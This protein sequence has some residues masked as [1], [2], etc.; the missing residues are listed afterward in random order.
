MPIT[1]SSRRIPIPYAAAR[2]G[3]STSVL[4]EAV[5]QGELEYCRLGPRRI[6][7]TTPVWIGEWASRRLL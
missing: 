6:I 3:L 7:C 5:T 2:L 1:H 4:A